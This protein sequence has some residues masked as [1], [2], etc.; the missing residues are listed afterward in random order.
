MRG[1]ALI[2][3]LSG[4]SL[5]GCAPSALEADYGRSVTLMAENQVYDQTT[6]TRPS[7]RAVVG[8]DPDMLN[9]AVTTLRTQAVDRKEVSKPIIVNIGGGQ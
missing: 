7:L 4:F 9:L 6:L 1:T 3:M 5:A 2:V 8:A